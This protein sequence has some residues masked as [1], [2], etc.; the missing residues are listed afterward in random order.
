MC[1]FLGCEIALVCVPPEV[2][3]ALSHVDDFVCEATR[4]IVTVQLPGI[5]TVTVTVT[6]RA[7]VLRGKTVIGTVT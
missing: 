2:D 7:Q 5:V 6:E 3:S 1:V 4:L